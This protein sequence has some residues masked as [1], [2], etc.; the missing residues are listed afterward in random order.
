[1]CVP[2]AVAFLP[3]RSVRCA[4]LLRGAATA[5][6]AGVSHCRGRPDERW[7]RRARHR[8]DRIATASI[9]PKLVMWPST[10]HVHNSGHPYRAHGSLRPLLRPRGRGACAPVRL[11]RPRLMTFRPLEWRRSCLSGAPRP[12][13]DS[14]AIEPYLAGYRGDDHHSAGRTLTTPR[15]ALVAHKQAA[16]TFRLGGCFLRIPQYQC[17]HLTDGTHSHRHVGG[18]PFTQPAGKVWHA[19]ATQA[20]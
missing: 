14:S 11:N 4:H 2:R 3:D 5:S 9:P 15:H 19:Q 18:E 17:G 1:M 10:V 13:C 20:K 6:H 12:H 8:L 16:V 7:G